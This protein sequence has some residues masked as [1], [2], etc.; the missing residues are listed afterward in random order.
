LKE[1]PPD[2]KLGIPK[3]IIEINFYNPTAYKNNK[4]LKAKFWFDKDGK[5]DQLHRLE[6]NKYSEYSYEL[7]NLLYE[8][9]EVIKLTVFKDRSLKIQ[10]KEPS[11]FS[12]DFTFKIFKKRLKEFI[13]FIENWLFELIKEDQFEIND[14]ITIE[15]KE[16]LF[17]VNCNGK[18]FWTFTREDIRR[19][20]PLKP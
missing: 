9:G 14:Y 20:E 18:R 12:F 7:D 10:F 2:S 13:P 17:R 15:L 3:S 11:V 16:A 8:I 6:F 5:V 19:P 1:Y 4:V